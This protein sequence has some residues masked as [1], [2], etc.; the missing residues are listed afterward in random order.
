MAHLAKGCP[1]KPGR[2]LTLLEHGRVVDAAL[3]LQDN[4]IRGVERWQQPL[5]RDEDQEQYA[6]VRHS[7]HHD[8]G[9]SEGQL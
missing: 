9:H 2:V 4:A 6:Q 1:D 8:G 3:R 7:P 5:L